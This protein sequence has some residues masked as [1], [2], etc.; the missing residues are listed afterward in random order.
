VSGADVRWSRSWSDSF[1]D[2]LMER[3]KSLLT[4]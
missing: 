1:D 3:V 4:D 2:G